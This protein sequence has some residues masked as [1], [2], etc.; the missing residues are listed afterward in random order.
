MIAAMKGLA[1]GRRGRGAHGRR[2]WPRRNRE[3][4]ARRVK[5][6]GHRLAPRP[7]TFPAHRRH[8]Y[9]LYYFLADRNTRPV[10]R[11]D[12]M[13]AWEAE[14]RCHAPGGAL[15]PRDPGTEGGT[16]SENIP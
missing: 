10:K 13:S 16:Q 15:G 7:P 1:V 5:P 11:E 6:R 2:G 14:G 4:V 8:H 9:H 12:E 3:R